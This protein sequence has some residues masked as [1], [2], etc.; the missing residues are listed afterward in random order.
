MPFEQAQCDL[1]GTRG[2]CFTWLRQLG[3][4][5]QSNNKKVIALCKTLMSKKR[6]LK[7]YLSVPRLYC[8]FLAPSLLH[9]HALGEIARLVNVCAA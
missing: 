1:M 6:R 9:R 2:L 8:P 3:F 5:R 4:E 7:D